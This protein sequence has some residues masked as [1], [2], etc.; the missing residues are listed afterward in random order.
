MK[1][2]AFT[3]VFALTFFLIACS[4][5]S[6][7]KVLPLPS[8]ATAVMIEENAAAYLFDTLEVSEA[9]VVFRNDS[10][11]NLVYAHF[12]RDSVEAFEF[13]SGIDVYHPT[14]SPD[15]KWVAFGTRPEA[16]SRNSNVYVQT[17]DAD[18]GFLMMLDGAAAIPRFRVIDGDTVLIYV[19]NAGVN[20]EDDFWKAQS[21]WMVAF[22]NETFGTPQKIF[23]G[24]YHGG[25]SPDLKFAVTGAGFLRGH[26]ERADEIK[27]T[28]WY[29]SAQVCNVSLST[30]GSQRTLFLDLGAE[31]GREFSGELYDAHHRILIADSLG[32]LIQSI[33]P[34]SEQYSYD[35]PEWVYGSDFLVTAM[36]TT[37]VHQKVLL[38]DIRDSSVHALVSGSDLWHPDVWLGK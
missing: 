30:D 13:V 16:V 34:I 29:D 35:H 24:N 10:S 22:R 2:F 37:D 14:I 28:I 27:D 23:T 9:R 6:P 33:P 17:L 21:T 20:R 1:F 18:C 11:G 31:R 3:V 5:N 15:G 19:S 12:T 4:E 26:S 36:Q 7:L 25:V 38:V 32:N 8:A